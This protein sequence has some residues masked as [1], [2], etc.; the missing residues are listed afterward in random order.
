MSNS[1]LGSPLTIS[2]IWQVFRWKNA[3]FSCPTY[4]QPPIWKC[5]P[6]SRWLKFCTPSLT[7]IANYSLK[8]FPYA[9]PLNQGTSVMNRETDKW[10]TSRSK[11]RDLQGYSFLT[12]DLKSDQRIICYINTA[13]VVKCVFLKGVP[14][15]PPPVRKNPVAQRHEI[16]SWN[17]RDPRLSDGE[18]PKSLII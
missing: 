17:I 11:G 7:P 5:S 18:N 9:L 6:C 14:L 4:I 8:S 13:A 2:K 10:M 16:L 12:V 15:F 3:H 1:N